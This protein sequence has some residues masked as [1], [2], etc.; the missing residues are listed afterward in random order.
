MLREAWALTSVED[1]PQHVS[2]VQ[3]NDTT[4]E[5]VWQKRS[6]ELMFNPSLS[7]PSCLG[8]VLERRV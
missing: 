5:G 6:A 1:T 4:I 7:S 3:Y 8:C 2:P